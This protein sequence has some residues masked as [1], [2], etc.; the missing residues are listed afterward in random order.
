MS[1]K[2]KTSGIEY[3]EELEHRFPNHRREIHA[4]SCKH[5]PS[6]HNAK[7]G[8][9]DPESAEIA[10]LPKEDIVA[11]QHLFVCAWRPNKLCKGF[12]DF[13][14]IDEDFIKACVEAK[15]LEAQP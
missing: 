7:A 15:E 10:T 11:E 5:C 8:I 9:I 1:L 14:G 13:C 2:F 12:C 4:K 6:A 3:L